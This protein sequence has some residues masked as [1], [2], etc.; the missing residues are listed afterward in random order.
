VIFVTVGTAEPFDRL[1]EA[2][3]DLDPEELVVQC[4]A[5]RG[6][7]K[8]ARCMPYLSYDELQALVRGARVVITHA[9]VGTTLTAL[10]LG[11]RPVLVPR[12]RRY[13][14]AVDDHQ[15]AFARRLQQEGLAVMVEDVGR[16]PV[17][18]RKHD[19][20]LPPRRPASKQL[21]SELRELIEAVVSRG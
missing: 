8:R 7:P 6:A 17:V 20:N 5:S 1:V 13:G 2:L 9:G 16:L 14:E 12:L 11:K 19:G 3:D 21:A 10:G 18:V 15:V 4:G